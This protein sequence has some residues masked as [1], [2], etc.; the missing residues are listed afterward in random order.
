[1]NGNRNRYT[2]APLY[3]IKR[4]KYLLQEQ[5][6]EA[7]PESVPETDLTDHA[8]AQTPGYTAP[9]PGYTPAGQ[10]YAAPRQA[11]PNPYD[12]YHGQYTGEPSPAQTPPA[13]NMP[14][15]SAPSGQPAPFVQARSTIPNPAQAH[16]KAQRR[17]RAYSWMIVILAVILPLLFVLSFV[18][19]GNLLH[20]LF[21]VLSCSALA[22][23]WLG[24]AFG[25]NARAS[26]TMVYFAL[27]VVS[28]VAILISM[29]SSA[30]HTANTARGT[31]GNLFGGTSALSSVSSSS[32][33]QNDA[34]EAADAPLSD[35]AASA[36]QMQ[37]LSF[38]NYWGE[39]QLEQ[40]VSLCLPAWVSNQENAKAALFI[41]L[42]NR[43]PLNYTIDDVSGSDADD[44][45]TITITVLISKA[46]TSEPEYYR[47]QILM[48]R[49]NNNWYVDPNSLSS[50]KLTGSSAAQN[51]GTAQWT[52][53]TVP[54]S[55][56]EPTAVPSATT[57]LYYNPDGGQYYHAVPDCS[58]VAKKYIPLTAF[59]YADLN[60][61][62]FKNLLPC[63]NCNPPKRPSI[64]G[65]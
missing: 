45:R 23:M 54:T 47:M 46:S 51:S 7:I 3:G 14:P 13:Q 44:S 11:E 65:E 4:K 35:A 62:S 22:I 27:A 6:A 9:Q 15:Q 32:S 34:P 12:P 30:R 29:P 59:Y 25:K 60:S 8:G 33:G 57:Q 26:L 1:M 38:M 56:P 40:M 10:Q 28:A 18:L 55:V 21:L 48:I 42:A 2:S 41:L 58:K 37:L 63:P 24:R 5:E 36:A 31:S 52:N 50:T 53:T 64:V 61:S 39:S 16:A 19:P 43:T 20:I 49:V 17:P